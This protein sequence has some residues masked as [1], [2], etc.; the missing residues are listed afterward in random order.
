MRQKKL[1]H[2]NHSLMLRIQVSIWSS[3]LL[4]DCLPNLKIKKKHTPVTEMSLKF[5][6]IQK[7]NVLLCSLLEYFFKD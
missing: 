1:E 4:E 6:N 5:T 7:I 2:A 3:A